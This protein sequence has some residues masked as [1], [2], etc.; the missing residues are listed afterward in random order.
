MEKNNLTY[1][2]GEGQRE[3]QRIKEL[4]IS[5]DWITEKEWER[6]CL[7]ESQI[8]RDYNIDR[9]NEI[10]FVVGRYVSVWHR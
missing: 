5:K 10:K 6:E 4:K 1:V 8:E 3:S 9:Y 7:F 2:I